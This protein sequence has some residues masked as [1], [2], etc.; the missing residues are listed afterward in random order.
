M[1]NDGLGT[2][3]IVEF[4]RGQ[5]NITPKAPLG[6][7]IF[8]DTHPFQSSW[9]N[10]NNPVL[11]WEKDD[12]VEGFSYVLD[13]MPNTIPENII[14]TTDTTKAFE[15][16]ADGLWYFHIKASKS[17]VWGTTGTFLI[18]IDTV[19]P[20]VFVPEANY[21]LANIILAD[22]TLVSFFT[23]DNLSGVDHYEV[24]VIDKKQPVTVSPVFQEADSPF[25]V[26]LPK[27]GEL[28]IIVRALD[29][30]GNLRDVSIDVTPPPLFIKFLKDNII[31]ILLG[32]ILAGFIGLILHYLVGHHIIRNLKRFK[33][34]VRREEIEEDKK[35]IEEDKKFE[36]KMEEKS[37]F[38]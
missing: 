11:S 17:K 34:F 21:L 26:P 37:T 6:V 28:R 24:G 9:Y 7:N 14:N 31:Y 16:L 36:Q 1:L 5:Y 33:S 2:E 4:D 29:K 30:A 27:D 23:T 8:S 18:R 13:N 25:Q 12:K 3:S 38:E 19:P 32:I 10:N 35:V 22:R 15:K 20:A